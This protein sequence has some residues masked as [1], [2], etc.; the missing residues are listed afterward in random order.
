MKLRQA[1][2]GIVLLAL[3]FVLGLGAPTSGA[4]AGSQSGGGETAPAPSPAAAGGADY[5]GTDGEGNFQSALDSALSKAQYA[6]SHV[7]GKVISDVKFDWQLRSIT[8]SRG[9]ITGTR[10][11][12][13]T[14]HVGK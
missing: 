11:V 3:L 8:G 1:L 10:E 7:D 14:I 2:P 6:C 9:G 13:V 4:R 12:T 5:T